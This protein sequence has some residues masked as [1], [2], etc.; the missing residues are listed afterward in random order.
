MMSG[1]KFEISCC[2]CS[3]TFKTEIGLPKG[4]AS[5]Y[6]STDEEWGFCPKHALVADFAEQQCPGCVGGWGDCNLFNAFAYQ[7]WKLTETD[8]GIIESGVCPKRTN[9]T[10]MMTPGKREP[11]SLRLDE[12]ASSESGVALVQA[13]REYK[14]KWYPN[15]T[16]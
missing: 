10:F 1:H 4:W 9:G 7:S 2:F 3:E 8:L 15:E 6:G 12:Q 14:A 16:A 5:R 13:L 11:E